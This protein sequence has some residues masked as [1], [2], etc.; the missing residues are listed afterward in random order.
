M[1]TAVQFKLGNITV[2]NGE[3]VATISGITNEFFDRGTA[4]FVS[5]A[6]LPVEATKGSGTS[7]LALINAWPFASVSNQPFVAF[8]TIEGLSEAMRLAGVLGE[9]LAA[10]VA[11]TSA[12]SSELLGET[13]AA[14][15]RS[16]LGL[17]AIASSGSAADLIAGLVPNARISETLDA[18]QAYRQGNILGTVSQSSGVPTGAIIQRGSNANGEFTIYA[19]GTVKC[20]TELILTRISAGS[21]RATW[22]FP[23]FVRLEGRS[24]SFSV[25]SQL[26]RGSLVGGSEDLFKDTSP[27]FLREE[28]TTSCVVQIGSF[29]T[30]S[31]DASDQIHV[32]AEI[33]GRAWA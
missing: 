16:A 9:Q 21:I 25:V 6:A 4:L 2:N 13:N 30:Y 29:G 8:N 5:G 17:A 10:I 11:G 18:A 27:P 20:W 26:L 12:F 14:G 22:V 32:K 31:W 33:I 24:Y 7:Q 15:W 23:T 3:S 19:D 28:L 1:A